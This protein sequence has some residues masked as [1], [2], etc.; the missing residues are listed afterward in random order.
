MQCD[1][2]IKASSSRTCVVET[3]RGRVLISERTDGV[4]LSL[5]PRLVDSGVLNEAGTVAHDELF[6]DVSGAVAV[7]HNNYGVADEASW[8]LSSSSLNQNLLH[9]RHEWR[10][11]VSSQTIR[12]TSDAQA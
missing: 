6:K 4:G 1:E 12:M 10:G 5:V 2:A 11:I 9:T 8:Q 7:A 3:P